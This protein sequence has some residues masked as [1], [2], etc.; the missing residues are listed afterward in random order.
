MIVDKET[1]HK[2]AHLSRLEI[3]PEAEESLL[4]G[5]ASMVEWVAQLQKINTESVKP[6][7]HISAEVNTVR[8]DE[9]EP[10]LAHDK[11]LK[12]APS[13]DSDY[14]RVPKVID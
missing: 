11:A 9:N 6:L 5:L 3:S 2:V 13:K 8:E 14:F 7:V 10:H 1:L 12:N 4:Q